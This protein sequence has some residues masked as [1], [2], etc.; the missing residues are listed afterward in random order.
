MYFSNLK[1]KFFM[2]YFIRSILTYLF[3]EYYKIFLV[4][5]IKFLLFILL[6]IALRDLNW[7]SLSSK[8]EV[9]NTAIN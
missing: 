1:L 3:L 7:F 9:L 6:V 8:F 2:E 5:C 4:Y